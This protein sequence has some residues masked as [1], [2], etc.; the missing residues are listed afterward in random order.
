MC[1]SGVNKRTD[2]IGVNT[3]SRQHN[4]RFSLRK[5]GDLFSDRVITCAYS[6][7]I[8]DTSLLIGGK[9]RI[10]IHHLFSTF[11]GLEGDSISILTRYY[12]TKLE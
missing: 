4:V 2:I 9:S 12:T 3:S 10:F 8:S 6:L 11:R 1:V 7:T 5:Y